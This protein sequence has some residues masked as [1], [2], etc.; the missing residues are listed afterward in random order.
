MV[1]FGRK[2]NTLFKTHSLNFNT[3]HLIHELLS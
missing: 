1:M 3:R 2:I